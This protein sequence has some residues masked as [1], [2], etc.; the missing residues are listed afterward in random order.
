MRRRAG[1]R[2]RLEREDDEPRI[3]LHQRGK[4]AQAL[5]AGGRRERLRQQHAPRVEAAAVHADRLRDQPAHARLASAAAGA[6]R[7][8]GPSRGCLGGAQVSA[9]ADEASLCVRPCAQR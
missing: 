6:W 3:L 9:L 4:G 2:A 8:P 5:A 1:C 7:A